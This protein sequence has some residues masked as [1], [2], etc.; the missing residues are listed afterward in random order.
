[1]VK[2]VTR[3]D[4][5]L[6]ALDPTRGSE[7]K[8]TRPCLIISPDEINDCI[9]TVIIAPM[10]TKTHHDY[11]SRIPLVFNKKQGEIALDQLRTVDKSRLLKHLGKIDT[12]VAKKVTSTLQE[13]FAW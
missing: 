8:K 2:K 12:A 1:M 3:F 6:V 9:R 7:I 13:L 11:V 4:V 5:M 10:T